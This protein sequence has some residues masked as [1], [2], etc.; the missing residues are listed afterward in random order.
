MI[1]DFSPAMLKGFLHIRVT[2]EASVAMYPGRDAELVAKVA[3]QQRAD[4]TDKDFRLAWRGRLLAPA[5][6]ERLW[7]ALGVPPALFGV[8]LVHGGQE[9]PCAPPEEPAATGGAS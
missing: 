5:P 8:T 2:H 3:L 9:P 1:T 4:V 6:R 7:R